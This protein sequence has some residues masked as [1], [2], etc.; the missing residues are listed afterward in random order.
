M[1]N[2]SRSEYLIQLERKKYPT[3]AK[4]ETKESRAFDRNIKQTMINFAET[5]TAEFMKDYYTPL[6]SN[7][8]ALQEHYNLQI[9][10]N[11]QLNA[12]IVKMKE[13][14]Y[15]LN[16]LCHQDLAKS[17]QENEKLKKTIEEQDK[18]IS[19]L[20]GPKSL[21][22]INSIKEETKLKSEIQRLENEKLRLKIEELYK[23]TEELNQ[24]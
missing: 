2:S 17:N 5:R 13:S 3:E 16:V 11:A 10:N 20:A 23:S 24:N 1:I 8:K 6:E 7:Y 18:I 22:Y 19:Q 21:E 9:E 14:A 12:T 4:K 15:Q